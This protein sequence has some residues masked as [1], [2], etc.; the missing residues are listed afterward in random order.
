MN[1]GKSYLC[2]FSG[3]FLKIFIKIIDCRKQVVEN[4]N[5]IFLLNHG[6]RWY[7]IPDIIKKHIAAV[8]L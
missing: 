3:I 5:E 2:G 4:K 1:A 8:L 7:T 6:K